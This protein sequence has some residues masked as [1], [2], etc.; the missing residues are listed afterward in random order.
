MKKDPV[1]FYYWEK[2]RT[3]SW[4]QLGR[5]D[6]YDSLEELKKDRMIDLNN[7]PTYAITKSKLV[8]TNEGKKL[9][10]KTVSNNESFDELISR[11]KRSE[12]EKFKELLDKEIRLSE[13][14]IKEGHEM[15]E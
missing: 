5:N 9:K 15:R 12:L 8:E 10:E 11:A 4:Q 13:E 7:N 1:R 14:A 6:G 2:G 3:G